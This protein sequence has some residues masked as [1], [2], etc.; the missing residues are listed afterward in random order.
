M[1]KREVAAEKI[2]ALVEAARRSPD[3]LKPKY[4][5][6]PFPAGWCYVLSE[7]AKWYAADTVIQYGPVFQRHEGAPH[8]ALRDRLT[9]VVLDLTAEQFET[10][11]DPAAWVGKGFLTRYPSE[12]ARELAR[13]AGLTTDVEVDHAP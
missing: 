10:P 6:L 1:S 4:R 11:P 7:A 3:L 13:R 2:G 5:G 9:G 12:R 8:W